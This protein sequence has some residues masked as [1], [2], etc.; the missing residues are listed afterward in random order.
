VKPDWVTN[1]TLLNVKPAFIE[2]T[3][4]AMATQSPKVRMEGALQAS[5]P[6]TALV[7]FATTL[8]AEGMSQR[9]LYQLFDEY[10]AKHKS[11]TDETKYDAIL[12]TMDIIVGW[13]VPSR[14][15]FD[16]DLRE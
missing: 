6:Y 8:K 5:S 12:D 1:S 13:C 10:R 2:G 11:D 16:S 15:L 9:E 4:Y 7:S 14:R 3:T